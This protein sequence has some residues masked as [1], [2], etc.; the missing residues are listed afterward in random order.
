MNSIWTQSCEIP[1]KHRLNKN[2]ETEIVVIGAGL[3][4]I[5]IAHEL[6]RAGKQVVILEANR[7]ASG[8]TS[9]TTAKITS[10]HNFIYHRLIKTFGLEKARQYAIANE[11][12]L[13]QY[14]QL[15]QEE[16]VSCDFEAVDSYLYSNNQ[17]L[18]ETELNAVTQLG[19]PASI[20][21]NTS[22]P[23]PM[24][25]AIKF[26]NQA[27]FHPLKFIKSLVNSLDI[28][29]NT[30]VLSVKENE[31]HTSSGIVQ[32]KSIVFATHF[33][34]I[35]FP[36]FYFSRMHQERSYVL[37]LKHAPKID[38]MFLGEGNS[39]YSFRSY[40]DVLLFGGEKHRCGE[41]STG[42]RYEALRKKARDLFPN[43]QEIAHWS[44]QD[45]MTLDSV[46]YIGHYSSSSPNW[47][48]ATGFQKWGMTTSMVAATIIRDMIC[49][50][51]NPNAEVFSP[52][53]FSASQIP[54]LTKESSKA[55]KGL[56][57]RTF[58]IPDR[59]VDDLS[60][61][62]GGVVL[63]AG[64]KVGVY[65]DHSG[66]IY[67]VDIRCP[68]LGCQLEWN[69]DERS[70]DCPCHGSSFDYQGN[71]ISNPAQTNIVLDE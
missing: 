57:R 44:A 71:L 32:A 46:P 49:G 33:P 40:Q 50:I 3:A 13:K 66:T 52:K 8:Q 7:I 39:A 70:W 22:L 65:K 53:R 63:V 35:N 55:L 24:A 18:L 34:F 19:L 20:H 15:I 31:I 48:V 14:K 17:S 47:Y 59:F 36:G 30:P 37:A 26:E 58:Q 27:Q 9:H 51:Q 25:G 23:I 42:D 60:S 68:H 38:G 41:N 29:E 6:K 11:K 43:S 12:A 2:I 5:L 45:C 28:Y 4:G 61:G 21:F 1:K 54:A 62:H 16:Q 56:L 69:P 10:Q 64:E 67:A